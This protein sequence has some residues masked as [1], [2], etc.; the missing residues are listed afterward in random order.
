MEV[1][2]LL[3]WLG[4][5]GGFR[6]LFHIQRSGSRS[7]IE[8]RMR[9]LLTCLGTLF[10]ARGFGWLIPGP[11]LLLV[12]IPATLLPLA[13]H[14]FVE[15]LLR[16]HLPLAMK[17]FVA[18]GTLLF[19][20]VDL[21]GY[22]VHSQGWNLA[23]LSFECATLVLLFAFLVLRERAALSPAENRL[24]GLVMAAVA[25]AVPLAATDFRTV[26]G[27]PSVRMGALGA[28]L[29]VF[30]CVR[31]VGQADARDLLLRDAQ[32]LGLRALVLGAPLF[33]LLGGEAEDALTSAALALAMVLLFASWDHMWTLG[34]QSRGR[35]FLRWM[36]DSDWSGP[37]PF[38]ESLRA[39]P[40][41]EEHLVLGA[42]H[43]A[44]FELAP[45]VARLSRAER[46]LGRAALRRARAGGDEADDHLLAL[47]DTYGMSHVC[48]ASVEP[49]LLLLFNY[50]ELSVGTLAE[51]EMAL[52]QKLAR[53]VA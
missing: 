13:M 18:L 15:G 17:A 48:L 27:F 24:V 22:L 19:L 35:S 20:A 37:A 8:G 7:F 50:P 11:W 12:V 43:L 30:V 33:V 44:K 4:A 9:F 36:L 49:P 31:S 14:L 26:L 52:V 21:G 16:R 47:L 25:C 41:A 2:A 6:Y 38:L 5:L 28:L 40:V 34:E 23:F 39:C 46:V 10:L 51:L 1:D 32:R 3:S 45:M 29:F 53:T 42:E